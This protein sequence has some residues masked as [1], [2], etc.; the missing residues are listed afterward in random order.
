MPSGTAR[1]EGRSGA[2]LKSSVRLDVLRASM[3]ARRAKAEAMAAGAASAE[4]SDGGGGGG[5]AALSGAR[6]L[7]PMG[8]LGGAR[9]LER[10]YL[11]QKPVDASSC[12]LKLS[13]SQQS[14]NFHTVFEA[15]PTAADDRPCDRIARNYT[16]TALTMNMSHMDAA[17]KRMLRETPGKKKKKA[18]ADAGLGSSALQ[19]QSMSSM[20]SSRAPAVKPAPAPLSGAEEVRALSEL[21]QRRIRRGVRSPAKAQK[22]LSLTQQSSLAG[23]GFDP[24]SWAPEPLD[25]GR[26]PSAERGVADDAAWRSLETSI[27]NC[28]RE[29][30]LRVRRGAKNAAGGMSELAKMKPQ[31][32]VNVRQRLQLPPPAPGCDGLIAP[33]SREAA[34]EAMMEEVQEQRLVANAM[35]MMRYQLKDP[36]EQ[37]LLQIDPQHLDATAAWWSSDEYQVQEWRVLRKTGVP[38]ASVVHAH[39]TM[40]QALCS[41]EPSL[42][43]LQQ[44]WLTGDL[45]VDWNKSLNADLAPNASQLT[46]AAKPQPTTFCSVLFTDVESAAFRASL[47]MTLSGF[48]EHVERHAATV[49]EAF[50]EYWI[51]GAAECLSHHLRS[52]RAAESSSLAADDGVAEGAEDAHTTPLMRRLASEQF[53][54]EQDASAAAASASAPGKALAEPPRSRVA[55]TLDAAAML[56]CRQLRDLCGRSI[57]SVTG[58]VERFSHPDAT[59]DS[60]FAIHLH[61]DEAKLDEKASTES[62]EAAM[63]C[64]VF[65]PPLAE[66]HQRVAAA[67]DVLVVSSLNFPRADLHVSPPLDNASTGTLAPCSMHREDELVIGAK[68]RV[69][70]ALDEHIKEPTKLFDSFKPFIDL[71]RNVE[72]ERVAAVMEQVEAAQNTRS[73]IALLTQ[74]CERLSEIL[75]TIDAATPDVCY[76]SMFAVDCNELKARLVA[77]V[78][79]LIDGITESVVTAQLE[80]MDTMCQEYDRIAHKLVHE[81]V[82]SAELQELQEFSDVSVGL[83]NELSNQL[84]SEIHVRTTFILGMQAKRTDKDPLLTKQQHLLLRATC[85]WPEKIKDSQQHSWELQNARKRELEAVVHAAQ[86]KLVRDFAN[87]AKKIERLYDEGSL[88]Q[89][90]VTATMGRI[91]VVNE[92]LNEIENACED[93]SEQEK[94]LEMEVTDNNTRLQELKTE[95]QPLESLWSTTNEYLENA[96]H[97]NQSPLPTIDPEDAD[98]KADGFRRQMAKMQKALEKGGTKM[99]QPF[100][101][102]SQLKE[103][104][105]S[106]IDENIPLMLLVCTKGLKE[107]HWGDMEKITGVEINWS[108][109]ANMDQ[110]MECGL[111]HHADAIEETCVAATKEFSLEIAMDKMEKEWEGMVF[112]TK[113]YKESGTS[114]LGSVD[115]IQTVLDDQIVK[116]QAMAGS[117]YIKPYLKRIQHW[118]KIL[119]NMQ[120]IVDECLKVQSTWLYLEPIFSSEDI[121]RQMPKEGELFRKVDAIWRSNM[122]ATAADNDCLHVSERDG[123]VDEMKNANEMLDVIQKGLSDY[124]ETKRLYF[125]R[126]FFLSNDELLEILSETKDPL[127]VQPHCKK[128]FEGIQSLDF[129]ENLDIK[130]MVSSEGENVQFAYD[131]TGFPVVNPMNT[132]GNV[133]VWLL[134]SEQIMK[135]TVASKCD[136]AMVD[137]PTRPR[138]EFS[139]SWPGQVVLCINQLK[140]VETMESGIKE[141][142]LPAYAT[143]LQTELLETVAMVRGELP[144]LA[145]KS[146]SAMVVMDVH[147]RD[148]TTDLSTM[149]LKAA[150]DFD[151]A[152]QLRYY[153]L[154]DGFSAQSGEPGTVECKMINAMLRYAYEYLGNSGR[155]VITPLT[156]RCYRTL[157]G[158][159]H[160]G[161][162]GAPEG[163]AGTGKTET[164]KDLAKAV[165]IQCVVFNCSDSLDYIAMGKFFKGLASSGAW[166]CFDEFNRILLEVLSV[167][168]QQVLCIQLA[169]AAMVKEFMFEGTL[170]PLKMTC[171]PFITMNPGYA[172]RAELPDNLKVLFRTVAMM[173]PDYAMIGEI[174]L[175]SFGYTSGKEMAVK[176][177]MTYKLCSEQLSA[178]SHYDYGMRAVIA[179][180]LASGN[181]KRNEGHLPEDVL[182]LRSIIEVNLPKFLAPDVPLFKGITSDLF[183]G[184]E[185]E[186]PDRKN[187]LTAVDE[188]CAHFRLQTVAPFIEK[189]IQTY[190]MMVVRHSFMIVGKPFAGKSMCWRVLQ[191][192]LTELHKQFADDDRWRTTH[193]AVQNPKSITMGQL[194]G[195]FDPVSHEWS[196][197]VLAINYRNC[198][199]CNLKGRGFPMDSKIKQEDRKWMLFDGPV[200]AI[201]I[202]NMNT[203]MDDNKKLCLMSGEIMQMS[204][205]MSMIMEPMDLAVASPATVSRNGVIYM[206]P[207]F[208]IGWR[209][210]LHSWLDVL[211]HDK[212]HDDESQKE[213]AE[214]V[215]HPFQITPEKRATIEFLFEWLVEPCIAFVR[216]EC[217]EMSPTVDANLIQSMIN[218]MESMLEEIYVDADG[219]AMAELRK[220]TGASKA[221]KKKEVKNHDEV[222]E[223]CFLYALIWSVGATCD[224]DDRNNFSTFLRAIMEDINQIEEQWPGVRRSL[225]VRKWNIPVFPDDKETYEWSLNMPKGGGVHD[226]A[227]SSTDSKWKKW[228][229]TLTKYEVAAG[230]PFQDIVVPTVYTAQFDYMLDLLLTH[231]KKVLVCG[232]TGTGK[233]CYSQSVLNG[234]LPET[235]VSIP[236]SFSAKTSA[237]MTQDILDAKLD[238]RRK[239]V[240]GPPAGKKGIVFVDDL[241]MPEI[242][243]WGAQPP[244]EL[245]RNFC[246]KNSTP[247]G[248]YDLEEMTWKTIIDCG[249]L[250]AMGPPGG[251]RNHLTPRF[252]RHLNLVCFT[253]FDDNTLKRI[254]DTITD[255][256]FTKNGLKFDESVQKKAASVVNATLDTYRASMLNLLPTPLKS[257]YTFNLRDF[258]RVVGGVLTVKP[259]AGFNDEAL[260]RLWVHESMRVF[261]DRL[262]DDD[263]RNWFLGHCKEVTIKSYGKKFEQVFAGLVPEGSDA[264]YEISL[265]DTRR[266]IWGN[267]MNA[268]VAPESRS[269]EEVTDV[270]QLTEVME[271]YLTEF[272]ATSRKQ[273]NL[274]MFLFAIEHV[275]RISRIL[276]NAGGNALLVGVGGSGRQS[277]ARLAASI[278][279]FEVKQIEISKQYGKT[280]WHEDLKTIISAAGTAAREVVFLFSDTQIKEESFVEDINNMLNAGDVPNLFP[281]DER[282]QITEAVRPF[283]RQKFGKSAGDMSIPDLWNFFITRV[284]ARLHVVLAFSPI[285]DAFRARLRLFPSLVNCCTIDWFTAWSDDALIA[286]ARRFLGDLNM[287]SDE[288][289]QSVTDTCQYFH[290]SVKQMGDDFL[291]NERRITYVTPTSYL[292]LIQAFRNCI[293][294]KRTEVSGARM[295]YVKGLEQ[296]GFAESNVA[297]MKK[298]LIEL[299]PVLVVAQKDTDELMATIE[300]ALPGVQKKQKEVGADAA[301]AQAEADKV[302]AEKEGVEAD[303][304]EAIPALESAVKALNTLN[305]NDIDEVKK[306]SKPPAGVRLVCEAVCV[307]KSIKPVKVPDPDDPSRKIQDYWGPSQKMLSEATFLQDLKDYDKDNIDVKIIKTIREKYQTNPDFTPEKAAKASKACAGL[308]Q[309]VC[310]MDTYE[311]VAKVVGPKR[312]ALKLAMATLAV[313]MDALAAKK[314]ELKEV[315]DNLQDLQDKLD[316]AMKK[317]DDLLFQVDLCAKKLD[318]AESLISGLGGEKVRWTQFAADLGETYKKLLGDV[319]ISAGVIAYLGAFTSKFRDKALVDW[320][321]HC[322]DEGIP[323][324]DKPTLSNTMGEPVKIREWNI[325]GLPTDAFSVD[326]GILIFN[327]RRWP[328]CIDP[329]LQANKWIRNKE[330]E[331]KLAVIKLSGDDYLRTIENSVQFGT[332]VLLENVGEELDPSIEPILLKQVFKQGGV[333]CIR[334][335]DSTIEYSDLFRFYITTKLRNPHYL[336]EVSVKVTLLNFM[337]TP[338]GLQDQL[339]G[340]VVGEERSD[341]QEAKAKLI[342]EGAANKAKLKECEDSILQILAADGNILE[343]EGAIDALKQSKLISDDIKEKQIIAD[344]T[345]QEIDTVRSSY[346]PVAFDTQVLFFCIAELCNVEPVYQYSLEWFVNLFIN[347]IRKSQKSQSVEQRL[348]HIDEHFMLSLYRNICRSL[349]EKDK[350]LFSFLLTIDVFTAKGQINSDEWYF[351]L[352]GG[353][354]IDN[355][356]PNPTVDNGHWL[357]DK[358]W[359]E[360]CRMSEIGSC[361]GIREAFEHHELDWRKMYDDLNPHEFPLPGEWNDKL[362]SFQKMMCLRCIRPDKVVLAVQNFIIEMMGEIFVKPPPFVL[363]D[364][365][366]DSSNTTPLVFIL[367]PGSDPMGSLVKLAGELKQEFDFISL[368][369]GQGPIAERMLDGA[370]KKGTWVVLQNCHLAPSWMTAMETIAENMTVDIPHDRFRMW[371]T[372]YPSE[373]FPVAILQNGVKMTQEPPKGMR[374]NVLGSMCMD[375]ISDPE[376]FDGKVQEEKVVSFHRMVF[377]LCF[378]HALVQERRQFGP[379]GWNIAYEFNESDLRISVK[380]LASFIEENEET[381]FKALCYTV[382]ECNYGGR[383]TDDKD[384]R[385]LHCILNIC[386]RATN[387]KGGTPFSDSGLYTVPED[388][389]YDSMLQFCESLPLV[390]GPEV[391]GMHE[392]A[393]ITKDQNETAK[394]FT[395]ILVTQSSSGG[396]GSDEGGLTK[397]QTMELVANDILEKLIDEFDME[398]VLIRYPVRWDESMNT[399]LSN[400]LTRFNA[401]IALVKKT[402]KEVGKAVKGLVVM[403]TELEALGNA[404]FFGIIP[405]MWKGKS[406]PS[407]KPLSS[408]CSDL[409]A[410]L[411]F[412]NSWLQTTPPPVFWIGGFFFPQAFLTGASQNFA[413]RYTVPIDLIV[414]QNENMPKDE[415]QNKPKDGVYTKGLF[416]EAGRWDKKKK[417]LKE[418]EPKV[419]FTNA[420]VIWFKPLDRKD[421]ETFPCYECPVYKTSDRR[422]ILSTTG[423][424][425]NFVCFITMPTD[426]PAAHWT[427]R[428]TAMLTQL[429]D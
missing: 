107:R 418:S 147:N 134:Q 70:A 301:V 5:A 259:H 324:S 60:A 2:G 276:T 121:M 102:A 195:Q 258:S 261:G 114:I 341:L 396:G 27:A 31:V 395:N 103:E 334:L 345:E 252:V 93:I 235:Y 220:G 21:D 327:S 317:K 299:Q 404:L 119:T 145:R 405:A 330:E 309:W 177:V 287:P 38:Q 168:A 290:Q 148:T 124:L 205:T 54:D 315:E 66:I 69:A 43:G 86:E 231:D 298:E 140:W 361:K 401:L 293:E 360:F 429:D 347:S 267:Y 13:Q 9:S 98:M 382:G 150:T 137:Y 15:A 321:V 58:F 425:T 370:R 72:N 306:L 167:V 408:Y 411:E 209:P 113:A 151:W 245:L 106:F 271:A 74:E 257:H 208:V 379:L 350:L 184:I 138:L 203:V 270:P 285:G 286:V 73:K 57:D 115:D 37:A 65:N 274:V 387:L 59:G 420:P 111:Q 331:N 55:R 390:S 142:S 200:D 342:V 213:G 94:L 356:H 279:D 71:L 240:Y 250:A 83:L 407:L 50:L 61:L 198:A 171:C 332:P 62:D 56:M 335:G 312:E 421:L 207:E 320:V 237:N 14:F 256:Y 415:Y 49:R 246:D 126:F 210:L 201:W 294:L 53:G 225:E 281:Y 136:D 217:S 232:P 303:L 130:G 35:A 84:L 427:M 311:R 329:Q 357:S 68:K 354:A 174:L 118:E 269:Y 374:A 88:D 394:L 159:L 280:E 410:R 3:Q 156:D 110:M 127:R 153:W 76:F 248:W 161:L 23:A 122:A 219:H 216:R 90:M 176:I 81:P 218:V 275:S 4:A 367:S 419:L 28:Q 366:D 87:V 158:A 223:C 132:G 25:E 247:G 302:N 389:D 422:G 32:A 344:K 82:D 139:V 314:A 364:C 308:C 326:N 319:L 182:V 7:G 41:T 117:R 11:E 224:L 99:A 368:G 214:R 163:P 349:L 212:E 10:T 397:E 384:R 297:V 172:G 393:T 288:V 383:V 18:R 33:E 385:A 282:I 375:P 135:R 128:C 359:G 358:L 42:T 226:W 352:T 337:I 78:Q 283:A 305:K 238:R 97:W 310:A 162:G 355:P 157:M 265:D 278:C 428:G 272:N 325:Q 170:L 234:K 406:Y 64:L 199:T 380:Q 202:E 277:V 189:I 144:K 340:V 20:S 307:M 175:Y 187:F 289:R 17:S 264:S 190:E 373:D 381:P 263:D 338:E 260:V 249:L 105:D 291:Q 52:L 255:W 123:I 241:N 26:A 376:F 8:G 318:R 239:G 100:R 131:K 155:L 388:T 152:A 236:V 253:N 79:A 146:L 192:V 108:P 215:V 183:P 233:S 46:A 392:N 80:Q 104:L 254:F 169:K 348:G 414:F 399:V 377:C 34:A 109:D 154:D 322:K 164:T 51:G 284:R 125:S 133:E 19:Q 268:E 196:D 372:T 30:N 12:V 120:D 191:R 39:R 141:G 426:V 266:L 165:A 304:A 116:A 295:R 351:L 75:A 328:L 333:M 63:S 363:K 296:L 243:A 339:L 36:A 316:G 160:L 143:R 180:L 194:Y 129:A 402:L 193:V 89:R 188:A 95:L 92:Q 77:R 262:I 40:E 416:V 400:E 67:I 101:A 228:E 369:Q 96:N 336:P 91:T 244:I 185:I 204:A 85:G 166:A 362:N 413:R 423:H 251:G 398:Q 181:L 365:Y 353:V 386:Y 179:V 112:E 313:T 403:S 206:E 424:S 371:C 273:M 22:L 178:Q 1:D 292:E 323:C 45:P 221:K 48:S 197:G 227:Y 186:E 229:D 417:V 300:A 149:N 409:Y 24:S 47:P 230:T 44:L 242:E 29:V 222:I 211:R 391:F 343:N 6:E 378:F 173:V 346:D 16:P 412:M